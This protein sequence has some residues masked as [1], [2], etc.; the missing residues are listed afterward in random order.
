MA[1]ERVVTPTGYLKVLITI[2]ETAASS[3]LAFTRTGVLINQK[4][5]SSYETVILNVGVEQVV[6]LR[7]GLYQVRAFLGKLVSEWVN[8]EIKNGE[9][10][11][12][13]FHFGR[14]STK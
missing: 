5:T 8:T 7:E 10:T 3:M 13:I 1:E 14:E 11:S 4:D 9:M 2:D 12:K 6:A